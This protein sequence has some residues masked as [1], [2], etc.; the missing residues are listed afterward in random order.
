MMI[1][2]QEH[3]LRQGLSVDTTEEYFER[4]RKERPKVQDLTL[5]LWRK[6]TDPKK[7]AQLL[8]RWRKQ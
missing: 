8:E 2:Y 4:W 7:R 3:L 6:E 5:E 1:L